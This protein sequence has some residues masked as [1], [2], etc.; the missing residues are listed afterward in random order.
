MNYGHCLVLKD[1]LE[2]L[3]SQVKS[4]YKEWQRLERMNDNVK[5]TFGQS[6][7]LNRVQNQISRERDYD[8]S[9]YRKLCRRRSN[10]CRRI[11]ERFE[12]EYPDLV[13]KALRAQS[14]YWM[15]KTRLNGLRIAEKAYYLGVVD[16]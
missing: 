7:V 3:E 11:D 15:E 4:L 2:E 9:Y 5:D 12:T 14:E 16:V 8:S 13:I 10:L 1:Q 6:K